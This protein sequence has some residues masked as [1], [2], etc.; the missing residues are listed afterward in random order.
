MA[1]PFGAY[2]RRVISHL[3]RSGFAHIY[4]S[5]GGPLSSAGPISDR[6]NSEIGCRHRARLSAIRSNSNATVVPDSRFRR[7][8]CCT[9]GKVTQ[10]AASMILRVAGAMVKVMSKHPEA[11][12]ASFILRPRPQP[13]C[14]WSTI[15][16]TIQLAG[17]ASMPSHSRLG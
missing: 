4:T 3:K 8:I 17:V 10:S 6:L 2:N 12:I 5:D 7:T 16:S 1:I 15:T 11:T 14:A 13:R 9:G